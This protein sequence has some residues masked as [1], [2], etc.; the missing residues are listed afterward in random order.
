[1]KRLGFTSNSHLTTYDTIS[2]KSAV[3]KIRNKLF[4]FVSNFTCCHKISRK[5]EPTSSMHKCSHCTVFSLDSRLTKRPEM[6]CLLFRGHRVTRYR[7]QS[8]G[9]RQPEEHEQ[10]L[11]RWR[12]PWSQWLTT[13]LKGLASR[14]TLVLCYSKDI[15]QTSELIKFIKFDLVGQNLGYLKIQGTVDPFY[16]YL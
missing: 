11:Q 16:Q 8:S 15:A 3:K 10:G 4:V 12:Y 13:Y 9:R 2:R 14:A 1:M 6:Q 7:W 5:N